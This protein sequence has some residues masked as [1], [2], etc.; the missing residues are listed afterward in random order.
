MTAHSITTPAA[1]FG[2]VSAIAGKDIMQTLEDLQTGRL[3]GARH[4]K[5]ACGLTAFPEAIFTLADTL[6]S[7]DLSGNALSVL[8]DDL[9]RLYRLRILFCSNNRFTEFPAVLGQCANLS[10]IGF[11]ANRIRRVPPGALPPRLR[12]LILTDNEIDALPDDI[13]NCPDLQKLMLAGNQLSALPDGLARC[14]RL[15]L[16]RIAAN[17]LTQ[18]PAWLPELPRL[19][20]LA[21]AGNPFSAA[22]ERSTGTAQ[23]IAWRDLDIGE[24]LGEGASGHIYRALYRSAD[25]SRTVAVKVF[26]GAVTSDGLP[27]CE[28]SACLAAGAHPNL[29][30]VIGRVADHPDHRQG[31]VMEMID[32]RFVTLA[33]PP[34]LESCTR[35][36]YSPDAVFDTEAAF[37]I[38][39]GIAAAACHLHALGLMH[40]DL[41]AHN[42]LHDGRGA[43]LLG[44]F[45][46]ASFYDLGDASAAAFERLEVRAFGCLLEE[47][48]ARCVSASPQASRLADLRD[49]C[50]DE[51]PANRPSFARIVEGLCL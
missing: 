50:L 49:A 40:G 19:S 13:G 48:V 9:H 38:A 24:C 51:V 28:L 30:P 8:P 45:G 6:E 16:L 47:L 15:E 5:L 25:T 22:A 46:A 34:S 3:A 41:Y 27:D 29:I 17:R 35:D 36:I 33:G 37:A 18:L 43:A 11:K 14:T 7:L 31:L 20:W 26:K 44:D 10:M 4:V 23:P 32:T 2:C 39:R 42:I 12:W 1:W 21:F